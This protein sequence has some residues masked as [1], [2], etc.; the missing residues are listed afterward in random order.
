MIAQGRERTSRRDDDR[1]RT[2]PPRTARRPAATSARRRPRLRRRVR[3]GLV[4]AAVLA[5][6]VGG[7]LW[8][9]D[10]PLVAV[11][12]VDVTGTTG[13]DAAQIRQALVASGRTMTTLH[14]RMNS[15]DSA[16]APY[17]IV[18]QLRVS[19]RFPH[20]LRIHVIQE[21]PVGEVQFDGG[22][23][24]VAADGRLLRDEVAQT[25]LPVIPLRGPPGG[26]RLAD[27]DAL[28]ALAVL[29]AAPPPLLAHIAQ[30]STIARHGL[31][32][33]LRDGPAIYFGDLTDL[34][35]KW[36]AASEVLSDPGSAGGAYIDV[37]DPH[38]PAVGSGTGI[39]GGSATDTTNGSTPPTSPAGAT[40]G[41][42]GA[43]SPAGATG[44][45]TGATSPAGATGGPTG[46]TSGAGATAG[47]TGAT[48][49]AGATSGPA[50][51][52][53]TATTT[54]APQ[55]ATATVAAAARTA[56]TGASRPTS[57]GVGAG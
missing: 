57:V 56:S 48:S 16:V 22:A 26:R 36:M 23:V 3:V 25:S 53:Q 21:I 38:R 28:R 39:A 27:R 19:I 40:G 15:L 50:A 11:H 6:A 37:T 2:G 33:Q 12:R 7:W 34:Q 44:G 46:A 32:A 49:P 52:P 29:A 47:S 30:V 20:V 45:S 43:T 13:P 54:G 5:V 55:A 51:V 9:R 14:V 4:C 8:V 17:P 35:A 42:T 10:S 41:S 1:A 18:K 31:V 24:P